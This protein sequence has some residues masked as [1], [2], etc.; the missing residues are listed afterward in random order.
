MKNFVFMA[1]VI[2]LA[3]EPTVCL[4]NERS[5]YLGFDGQIRKMGFDKDFGG[6]IAK[7]KH[8][9]TNFYLGYKINEIVSIEVGRESTI[10]KVKISHISAGQA[11]NGVPLARTLH[12]AVFRTKIKA[13]GP[14]L[15]VVFSKTLSDRFPIQVIGSLG[16][17]AITL[18]CEREL[19]SAAGGPGSPAREMK[20]RSVALRTM[21][22]FQ[23]F[24]SEGVGVRAYV[25]FVNTGKMVV[26]SKDPSSAKISNT[27]RVLPKD[28]FIAGAGVVIRF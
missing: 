21:G 14:H 16:L 1:S 26:K 27:P 8:A 19:L 3:C 18:R 17:S 5:F 15:D 23:Y 9:Q 20:K 25:S 24:F 10:T 12:P 4:E 6:L 28:S 2:F 13:K 7:K 11:V 22:G